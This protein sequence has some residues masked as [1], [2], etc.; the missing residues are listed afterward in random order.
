MER[1]C[2]NCGNPDDELVPVRRMYVTPESWDTPGSA[3]VEP[4]VEMWCLSC[5]SQYPHQTADDD[6]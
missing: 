2:E 6:A 5:M 3:T 4:D 1:S